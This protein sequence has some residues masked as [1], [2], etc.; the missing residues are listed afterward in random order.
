MSLNKRLQ[1]II[2]HGYK[3]APALRSLMDGVGVTPA[4]IQ[5]LADLPKIPITTKDQ[6]VQM[7]AANPPFGGWLAVPTSEVQHIFV[8][9]GPIFEPG[10]EWTSEVFEALEFGP[11]DIVINTFAY[12]MVSAG[13]MMDATIRATGATVVPTGPGNTENQVDIMIRLGA[14]G[15]AGTP[16]FFK[17]ILEKAE[18]MNIPRQD[19]PIKKAFF[20]AEPYP[21]SLRA[22]FEEDYGMITSQGYATAELGVIAYDKTGETSLK[23]SRNMIVEITD[24]ESGQPVPAGEPGQVVVTTFNKTYPLVRVGLG[25]LSA[26]VGEPD[27]EGYHTHIK[28]WMG[29]V[30]DAIKVRGMFLHPVQLKGALAKFEALGNAQ[31]IVTRPET[32]DYVELRV[33]LKDTSVDKEAL[34]ADVKAAASQ[35]CRLKIDEVVFIEVGS[36]EASARTVVDE[37]SWE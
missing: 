30:G 28:G 14:V 31:A 32:R 25:D 8:S 23:L 24:P 34:S 2:S 26:F 10:H 29:R 9:P 12:H 5:S 37:R 13:L 16:S 18:A 33:E 1:E 20:S 7:Q 15:Y 19:I 22:I 27:D 21:P 36:I 3:N 4:E 35:A 6:L 11:G 17:I